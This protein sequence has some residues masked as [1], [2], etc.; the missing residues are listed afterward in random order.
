MLTKVQK[1]IWYLAIFTC[2]IIVACSEDEPEVLSDEKAITSFIF[3]AESNETLSEDVTASIDENNLMITATV[4]FGTDVTALEPIIEVSELASVSRTGAQDF[5]NPL[6]YVAIAEDGSSATYVVIVNMDGEVSDDR[7]NEKE[8]VSFIFAAADND[9]LIDDVTATIAETEAGNLITANV[10]FGTNVTAL[11]PTIEL[12]ALASVNPTGSQDFSELAFYTV[13]AENQSTQ[14]YIV[15][16]SVETNEAPSTFNLI[17]PRLIASG[18]PVRQL[19]FTWEESTDSDGDNVTYNFYLGEV[20]SIEDLDNLPLYAENLTDTNFV[21][22]EQLPIR[23]SYYWKVDA[24]DGKEA[25]HSNN[26]HLVSTQGLTYDPE[27]VM[28]IP[29]MERNGHTSLAY[30]NKLWVIGGYTDSPQ[31]DVWYSE[32]G[33][34]WILATPV[35]AFTGRHQHT[36]L[37]FDNKMWVIGG[38]GFSESNTSASNPLNDVWYSEDGFTWTEAT[39]EESFGARYRH[40]SVVFDNKM[41]VIGGDIASSSANDVWYSE[42]GTTWTE[43]TE[44]AAFS[45]RRS[46]T[47]IVFDNKMWVMNGENGS[48]NFFSDVW[49][50]EEGITWTEATSDMGDELTRTT[51][52]VYADKMWIIA[53]ATSTSGTTSSTYFSD[54]GVNWFRDGGL[55]PV[56]N[57]TSVVFDDKI[58]SI[59][60]RTF[61]NDPGVSKD[62]VFNFSLD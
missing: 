37:V 11:V 2:M 17:S 57:H 33:I 38:L 18:Q 9:A 47:S 42:D 16:I 32:D 45:A 48:I 56:K 52:V 5:S 20:G 1:T 23:T 46:H 35:A 12:S 39:G 50:S 55:R 28:S 26:I 4:P 13:T 19:E 21:V 41:W 14:T 60:G 49:Y 10:P 61:F 8:I 30:D 43:A 54:D 44:A 36:S 25:T 24:T 62:E 34:T 51:S 53:G 7:S 22:T 27:T 3:T 15:S 6:S 31:N 59:G 29:Q 40:T 58:W